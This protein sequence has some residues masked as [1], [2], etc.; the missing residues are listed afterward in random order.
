MEEKSEI[1]TVDI[2]H[3]GLLFSE[4]ASLIS[5]K[6]QIPILIKSLLLVSDGD[7]VKYV[8]LWWYFGVMRN[9]LYFFDV[10][11]SI[12]LKSYLLRICAE[13]AGLPSFWSCEKERRDRMLLFF[14]TAWYNL[15]FQFTTHCYVIIIVL[16]SNRKRGKD[17]IF[18][19][20][21]LLL[22]PKRTEE[23]I[24]AMIIFM[25]YAIKIILGFINYFENAK[26]GLPRRLQLHHRPLS[27]NWRTL[28]RQ[29]LSCTESP[30]P[31]AYF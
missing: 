16:S 22:R 8:N 11:H 5:A 14:S 10:H 7:I 24:L 23:E 30:Q 27:R 21:F 13:T 6:L 4:I 18:L 17:V 19:Y 29:S 12:E 2:Y 26:I 20:I 1:E 9:K 31:Q 25:L 3:D 15:E 28:H